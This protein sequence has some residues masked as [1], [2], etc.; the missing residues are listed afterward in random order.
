MN[1]VIIG[2]NLEVLLEDID[3]QLHNSYLLLLKQRIVG[4]PYYRTN[5]SQDLALN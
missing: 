5:N 3:E 2:I 4:D 1:L